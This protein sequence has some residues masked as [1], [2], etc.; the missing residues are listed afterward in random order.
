MDS[1]Y[2]DSSFNENQLQG[3]ISFEILSVEASFAVNS[4]GR[5]KKI[6]VNKQNE[7]I[8]FTEDLWCAG[9][10]AYDTLD[11][12]ET[13]NWIVDA[14]NSL[15]ELDEGELI[16]DYIVEGLSIAQ[17]VWKPL[18]DMFHQGFLNSEGKIF[19]LYTNEII[20]PENIQQL[21]F[22]Q[23]AKLIDAFEVSNRSYPCAIFGRVERIYCIFYS[24]EKCLQHFSEN[25]SEEGY[26]S[27]DDVDLFYASLIRLLL[28][29]SVQSKHAKESA[30]SLKQERSATAKKA[31]KTKHQETYKIKESLRAW[32]KNN[33]Q[34][35][36]ING[37]LNQ[38]KAGKEAVKQEPIS[39]KKAAEYMGE[40]EKE[41]LKE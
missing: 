31:A 16:H 23:Q 26:F 11:L 6:L 35:F 5:L 14:R 27:S 1:N 20:T 17:K 12:D 19:T 36:L 22:F 34:H 10:Y 2:I 24:I 21:N 3:K 25:D 18:M 28:A 13:T 29:E 37:K 32:H 39:L 30:A 15:D 8:P 7:I 38:T 9:C 4:L 40:F 33:R 41:L